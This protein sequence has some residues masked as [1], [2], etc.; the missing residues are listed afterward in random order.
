MK[1]LIVSILLVPAVFS[2]Q[3]VISKDAEIANYVSQVSTDSLKSHINKLVS[4]GTRHTMSSV[5]DPK[6]GIGAARTW[7]LRKFKDYAKNTDGR[8]EAFLQNQIIQPD[9]KRIDK[10][11]DLGNPVA[12]LRGTDPNDKRIFMISGHLDSR[13]SDVMNS[14]DNAPGANDDGSGTAAVIESARILSKSKFPATIIFVAFSGEEQGLLGSKMMAEKVKNENWQLEAL[15]N[16][17]MISNN[18][19]SET[20]LINAHQLRVFS[21]GL[22]Q[23]ELDKKAQKIRSLGLENDGDARQLARY[24]KETGERYV[25]NLQVKLIYRNDRFLRGGDHSPFVER[26]YSAVRL[27][28]YNE[29]FDHQHQDIRKE[30]GK[31]YGDLPEFIDFDYFKKNVGVNVSVLANLAKSP[32]KPENVKMEV[33]ELT[34]YTSLSWEKPKSGEVTGYYVLMRETDSP[35]WQKKFFTKETFIK[36]PYSKDNCFF[37]VQAVNSTGNESLIV[38]P[39]VK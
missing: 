14:K 24:I 6:R 8:M 16:N 9:G 7:V 12:I 3:Q 33:K 10:P 26:G 27:T 5:T 15:L 23:Y 36:L 38:I 21:E 22:P 2:A 28:E 32:S 13:V 29:N 4:F 18:L 25:D 19:T 17:D 31:Q 20:N 39:G 1:K 11:T 35:V 34:N 30:N 37:A